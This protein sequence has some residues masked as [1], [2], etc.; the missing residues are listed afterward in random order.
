MASL[1]EVIRAYYKAEKE[2][3]IAVE[4][5]GSTDARRIW[6]ELGWKVALTFSEAVRHPELEEGMME[7]AYRR[8]REEV[9]LPIGVTIE[10]VNKV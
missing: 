2:L 7:E 8:V 9:G 3:Q 10:K 5:H 6:P 4:Y 1:A